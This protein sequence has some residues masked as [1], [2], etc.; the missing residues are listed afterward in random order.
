MEK[1]KNLG[2]LVIDMDGV[3][4]HDDDPM[5]G[6]A[7]FF[8]TLRDLEIP[9]VM[10][11]NNSSKTQREYVAKFGRFGVKIHE[12]EILT[13]SMATV[14]YMLKHIP[15][16][17]RR[18]YAIGRSGLTKPLIKDGFVLTDLYQV[19]P[20]NYKGDKA[21]EGADCVVVGVDREL[22]YDMLSTATLNIENGAQLIG[23]NPDKT[24]TSERGNVMGNGAILAA[25]TTAT[26]V[27][28]ITIG[29]PNPALY[30]YAHGI[31]GTT[32]ENTIAIGDTLGTDILGATNAGIRSIMVLSGVSNREDIAKVDYKPTWVMNNIS[33][34]ASALRNDKD[35]KRK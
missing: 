34:I 11:T 4:W 18:V 9:F 28:A 16:E 26:G 35:L 14:D 20:P 22:T 31:L 3:L 33:E 29:K 30:Y 19:D 7:D 2:G 8:N 27:E 13:S 12:K 32:R 6:L 10:A 15:K 25:L 23:T 21:K 1:I 5:D 24:S 17:K